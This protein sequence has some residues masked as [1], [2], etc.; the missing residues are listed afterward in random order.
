M[1]NG[2]KFKFALGTSALKFGKSKAKVHHHLF[3]FC[4]VFSRHQR[5]FHSPPKKRFFKNLNF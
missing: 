5:I 4:T 2:Q 3:T 1:Y